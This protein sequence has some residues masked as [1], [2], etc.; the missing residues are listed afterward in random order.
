[1]PH[2][3]YISTSLLQKSDV[4]NVEKKVVHIASTKIKTASITGIIII[5]IL[6][7]IKTTSTTAARSK[8]AQKCRSAHAWK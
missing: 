2:T 8:K 5:L 3:Q 6:L 1:M 4:G 7:L